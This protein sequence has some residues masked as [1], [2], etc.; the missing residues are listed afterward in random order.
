[1]G[2]AGQ[3]DANSDGRLEKAEFVT[4]VSDLRDQGPR[5]R[6]I[7][8]DYLD[9]D[10]GCCALDCVPWGTRKVSMDRQDI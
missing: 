3:F 10:M 7:A 8:R 6:F 5:D 2:R 9:L 4:L 1:M